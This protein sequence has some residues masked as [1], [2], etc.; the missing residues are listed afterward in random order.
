MALLQE[1]HYDPGEYVSCWVQ[2]EYLVRS[3][4]LNGGLRGAGG[5]HRSIDRL[6][7]RGDLGLKSKGLIEIIG[8][9][10]ERAGDGNGSGDCRK[11]ECLSIWCVW[12]WRG[13][14]TVQGERR[15]GE[16]KGSQLSLLEH[17]GTQGT[18]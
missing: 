1:L 10:T 17:S 12:A 16:G 9:C 14:R 13:H 3:P 4:A 2:L 18:F 8:P 11:E 7:Q 15:M 6:H 5:W